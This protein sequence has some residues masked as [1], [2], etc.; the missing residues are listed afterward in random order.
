MQGMLQK[1]PHS[2]STTDFVHDTGNWKQWKRKVE[3]ENVNGQ[4]IIYM[5]P[6][7]KPLY[8]GHLFK[9]TFL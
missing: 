4:I 1:Q 3:M 6:R 9:T 2:D 5:Y 8:S 7:V